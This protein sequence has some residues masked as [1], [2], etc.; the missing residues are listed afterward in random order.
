M[1]GIFSPG[2]GQCTLT[3]EPKSIPLKVDYEADPP[4]DRAVISDRVQHDRTLLGPQSSP[5]AFRFKVWMAKAT[6]DR[7]ALRPHTAY[8]AVPA[9]PR[10]GGQTPRHDASPTRIKASDSVH[11]QTL[12]MRS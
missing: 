12:L 7:T 8:D 3:T 4:D 2:R 9:R 1:P 6:H 10:H 11:R 5:S